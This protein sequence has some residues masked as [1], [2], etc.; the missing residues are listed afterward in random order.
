MR[1]EGIGFYVCMSEVY[2]E[3]KKV[4]INDLTQYIVIT[5][6]LHTL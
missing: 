4:Q 2:H 1:N 3:L 6:R 5:V